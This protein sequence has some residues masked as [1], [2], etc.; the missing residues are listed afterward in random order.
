MNQEWKVYLSTINT[1]PPEIHRAGWGADFPAPHNFVSIFTCM[2][3][4]N[5]TRWC[6]REYDAL[7]EKAAE[8]QDP[9]KRKAIYDQAQKIL[10]EVDAPIAPFYI[11]NQQNMIKPYVKGPVPNPLD[12]IIYK[13]V[14]FEEGVAKDAN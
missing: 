12:L 9:E 14:Y 1:D 10:L 2:S 4:N 3:G 8:E 7:V 11:S 6:N 13:D 5:R